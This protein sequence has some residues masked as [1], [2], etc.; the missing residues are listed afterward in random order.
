MLLKKT[1]YERKLSGLNYWLGF[2]GALER[3]SKV[4]DVGELCDSRICSK[5]KGVCCKNYP[6]VFAPTDFPKV[7]EKNIRLALETG[8]VTVSLSYVKNMGSFFILRPMALSDAGA[9]S[10]TDYASRDMNCSCRILSKEKGCML[11]SDCRPASGLLLLPQHGC[12]GYYRGIDQEYDWGPYQKLLS[13]L[14]VDNRG[15]ILPNGDKE[16]T[17]QEI[18]Q[19]QKVLRGEK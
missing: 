7:N 2:N 4:H 8:I 13:K 1:P 15:I 12:I 9:I 14:Y 19:L 3:G 16:A 11:D 5:C 10:S 17:E 6:C 18:K